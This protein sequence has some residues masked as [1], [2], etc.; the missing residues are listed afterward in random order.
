LT[1]ANTP[2]PWTRNEEWLTFTRDLLGSTPTGFTIL[3]TCTDIQMTAERAI[4][5]VH[6]MP[7]ES[8]APRV[9]RMF[10]T[11]FGHDVGA[12]QEPAV[13]DLIVAGIKWAAYR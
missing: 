13:M 7:P 10:Y 9:G 8:G 4:T 6:E 11:G 2:D 3:L 1:A 12:F 5:W